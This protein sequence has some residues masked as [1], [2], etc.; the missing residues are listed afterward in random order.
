MSYSPTSLPRAED[1]RDRAACADERYQPIRNFWFADDS[2]IADIRTATTICGH[3]P[4]REACLAAA[5]TEEQGRGQQSMYGI[6]GGLTAKQ[7]WLRKKREAKR[8]ARAPKPPAPCGT[9][10]AY[11]RHIRDDEPIDDACRAAQTEYRRKLRNR[12]ERATGCGTRSGYRVHRN[13]GEPACDACRKANA[14]ADRRLRN[15]G[16]TKQLTA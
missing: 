16:T 11:D 2:N 7:R 9:T 6:R 15:T 12:Q 10:A 14:D 8:R 1:W 3:C 5:S 13:N 4:V